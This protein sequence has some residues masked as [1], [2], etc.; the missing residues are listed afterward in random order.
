[1]A[2]KFKAMAKKEKPKSL[3]HDRDTIEKLCK[4]LGIPY[5]KVQPPN[6]TASIHFLN[7]PK[8]G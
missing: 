5:S 3:S 8:K 7:K 4:K 1:M 6:G 2:I